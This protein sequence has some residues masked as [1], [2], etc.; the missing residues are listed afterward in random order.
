[1]LKQTIQQEDLTIVNIYAPNIEAP[2]YVEQILM[3]IKGE[4]NNNT[5][6]VVDFN[7]PLISMHRTSRQKINK[8]TMALK[9]TLD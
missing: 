9:D 5:V 1:M 2:K 3:G 4:I 8:E 6:L 7:I